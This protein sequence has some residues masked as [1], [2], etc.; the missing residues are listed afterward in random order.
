[1]VLLLKDSQ[2]NQKLEFCPKKRWLFFEKILEILKNHQT[3]QN[4]FLE[5]VSNG[6]IAEVISKRSNFDFVSGEI[7]E[8]LRKKNLKFFEIVERGIIF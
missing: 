3:W 4:L 5:S 6:I 8:F 1:M 7:D 2:N